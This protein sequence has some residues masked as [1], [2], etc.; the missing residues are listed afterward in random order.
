MKKTAILGFGN[1]VRS[2]DGI[3][4]LVIDELKKRIPEL[5]GHISLIDMGTS[6]FE[7]LFQLKGHE[8]IIVVDAVMNTGEPDG[9]LYRLPAS[10]IDAAIQD[11]PLVF[12]HGLKWDQA[13]SY[14]KKILG[15]EYPDDIS[16]YLIAVTNLRIEL[17]ISEAVREAGLKV[18]DLIVAEI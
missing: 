6:A 4:C 16:V 8:R 18:A 10:A 13:L 7:M 2:D 15:R 3:G 17:G 11:D 1:P 5:P 14:A 12:L 9:T